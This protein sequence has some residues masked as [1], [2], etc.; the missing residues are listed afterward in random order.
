MRK[1]L[2]RV[3][4]YQEYWAPLGA[5]IG[6]SFTPL[7]T[8]INRHKLT[9]FISAAL[10]LL[11]PSHAQEGA[12]ST[13]QDAAIILRLLSTRVIPEIQRLDQ[14]GARELKGLVVRLD[15]ELLG[16]D[17][18]RTREGAAAILD[19]WWMDDGE[20]GWREVLETQLKNIVSSFAG[21]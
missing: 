6:L 14:E 12:F 9:L 5:T 8:F 7:L 2:T 19:T 21:C 15:L 4:F 18:N 1:S 3:L 16:A 11:R 17:A 20:G 10:E 13:R